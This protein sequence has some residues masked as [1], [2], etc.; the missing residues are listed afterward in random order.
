MK[1]KITLP[2]ALTF[3]GLKEKLGFPYGRTHTDRLEDPEQTR[4][5]FPKRVKL[6]EGRG[7]RIV[8]PTRQVLEWM[9]RRGFPLPPD[10][11]FTS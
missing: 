10:I 6:G 7:A 8:W 11:E 9:Q 5:P 1:G 4:D 2:L 3:D